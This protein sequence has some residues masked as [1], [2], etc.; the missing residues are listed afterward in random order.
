MKV[1]YFSYV[2]LFT[3]LIFSVDLKGQ[4]DELERLLNEEV[5]NINPVYKPVVGFGVGVLNYFGDIKNNYYSPSIGTLGYKVNISTYIDNNHYYKADFFFVGGSLTGNE[6]SYADTFRNFNFRTAIY[7]FGFDINYDFD[8]FYKNKSKRLHPFISLG[9]STTLFSSKADSFGTYI[10]RDTQA[11][12]SNQRYHYWNDGTIR[13]L[14][15]S[16]D[17]VAASVTMQRDF[18]YET[19][20]RDTDWGQGKYPQYAFVIPFDIGLDFQ[21]TERL[22]LRIGN[23]FCY[24]FTDL[25]DH[26]SHKNTSGIIGNSM[27]DIYNFTYIT[28]HLD[29][30]SSPKMLKVERLFREVE[31]DPTF[32]DDEDIDGVFDGWDECPGTP[33]GA[34]VDSFGCAVDSD[35]DG[36]ADYADKEIYSRHGAYVNDEGV[37]ITESDLIALLDKSMAVG[38]NEIDLYINQGQTRRTGKTTIPDKF[39]S[40]D[41][42]KD[43]YISFDEMLKEIDIFFDFQSSLTTEDIYELNGFFFSQ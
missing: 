12:V 40:I 33:L 26:V 6:R 7:N 25:L 29:L 22:M 9:F 15:Q 43:N 16:P 23:S 31:F 38:R 11:K 10:D 19:N 1:L 27:N 8:H 34:V 24:T 37:E 2:L 41:T 13:N 39:K 21:L 3:L 5:E 14:P 20:L 32:F 36:V 35:N 42:D 28:V 17:N 4:E 18:E 30:F